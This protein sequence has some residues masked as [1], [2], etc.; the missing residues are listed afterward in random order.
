VTAAAAVWDRGGAFL[1]QAVRFAWLEAQSCAFAALVFVGLA[2][3]NVVSLPVARYDALLIYLVLVTAAFW[4]LRLETGREVVAILGFH[5]V[6]LVFEMF[7]VRMGSWEYPEDAVTKIAGVPLYSGF[8]YAAVG[9]YVVR[10]WKLLDLDLIRYR[11]LPTALVAVAIYVNFLTHH[12]LPDARLALAVALVAVTW[13]SWITYQVGALRYRMPLA[14][15]FALIG[16]FL[17]L[18]EN[19]ATLFSAWRYPSQADGWTFVHV[20]RFGSWAL[21][22]VVSFVLV[23]SWRSQP[24]SIIRSRR[25]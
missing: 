1:V 24:P 2:L 22:V 6:G 11:P 5:L 16:F 15:S 21:L 14:L 9:S 18:A 8:M 12:W 25:R 13:G 3:S 20:G 10:A 4:G 23:A 17:W 19:L 7:K